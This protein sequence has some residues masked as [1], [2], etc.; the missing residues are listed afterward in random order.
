LSKRKTEIKLKLH[1]EK[2][3][4]WGK[5]WKPIE[6]NTSVYDD[7]LDAIEMQIYREYIEQI[8]DRS[9]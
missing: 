6:I 5:K 8:K 2:R 9:E 7:V 3:S 1:V 4:F